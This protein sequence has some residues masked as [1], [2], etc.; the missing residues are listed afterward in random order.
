MST[1]EETMNAIAQQVNA[2]V[3]G[4]LQG[5]TDLGAQFGLPLAQATIGVLIVIIATTF[6]ETLKPMFDQLVSVIAL[7]GKEH[8][9]QTRTMG[10]NATKQTEAIT[11]QSETLKLALE[12]ITNVQKQQ[13]EINQNR[14][15]LPKLKPEQPEAFDGKPE[16]VIPFLTACSL[17]FNATKEADELTRVVYA[18]SKIKGGKEESAMRWAN[19]KRAETHEYITARERAN[20]MADEEAKNQAIAEANAKAPFIGWETFVEAFKQHFMLSEQSE[21]AQ[22]ALE[23]LIMG[24]KSCEEYTTMFNGYAETS[25]YDEIYLLR[26]YKEGLNRQLMMNV[27]RSHPP[28]TT[29]K[30]WK[31]RSLTLDRE[32]RRAKGRTTR[33]ESSEHK[34]PKKE[35]KERDPNAMEIDAISVTERQDLM[36]KGACFVC[37]E[38]GHIA[39]NCPRKNGK[40]RKPFVPFQKRNINAVKTDT[41][42]AEEVGRMIGQLSPEEYEKFETKA[43]MQGFA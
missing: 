19:A 43:T 18:L 17:Y 2:Q 9:N 40:D 30:E 39:K 26:R 16:H 13:L 23:V 14:E 33:T 34:T 28:P 36:K 11:A 32:W 6:R 3:A 21:M 25:G 29:L 4:A 8:E 20:A 10:S 42:T 5:A 31:D 12:A 38:H 41:L 24:N 35:T 27:V 22:D 15:K 1:L 37:R 7:M